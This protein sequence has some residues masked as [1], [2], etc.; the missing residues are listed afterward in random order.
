MPAR[1]P[2]T[3]KSGMRS[4]SRRFCGRFSRTTLA[5]VVMSGLTLAAAGCT[6][7]LG[8]SGVLTVYTHGDGSTA[9]QQ[10]AVSAFNKTSKVQVNAYRAAHRRLGS[11]KAAQPRLSLR[12]FLPSAG[13]VHHGDLAAVQGP[14]R[15]ELRPRVD[16]RAVARV[17]VGQ[18][19]RV[20]ARCAAAAGVRGRLAVHA[21]PHV[22]LPGWRAAVP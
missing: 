7:S 2:V 17:P 16:G 15:P 18:H 14:A 9:V 3:A 11:G 13:A 1:Y 21:V 8:A 12:A 20:P 10:Q 22:D 19:P 4:L 6:S 5:L